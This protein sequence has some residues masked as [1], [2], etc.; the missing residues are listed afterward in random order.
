M[1]E[2]AIPL[3]G[4]G[5]L[6]LISNK[7]KD[8]FT[9]MGAEKKLQNTT[10]PDINYP[11]PSYSNSKQNVDN[12]PVDPTSKNYVHEFLNPNSATNKYVPAQNS[13]NKID[14]LSGNKIDAS[15]FKHN[16]MVPF[17]GSKTK[18]QLADSNI[19][20]AIL[21]NAQ[22]A[23]NQ[24]VKKV[25]HAP[26]FKPEDNVQNSNGN[27]NNNDFYQSRVI[28]GSKI[29][30]VLPWEQERVAPGLGL[31]Y[32]TNG[33]GGFNSGML[34]RE[35]WMDPTIDELRVKT[36][37]KITYGLQGH[38]GPASSKI[39]NLGQTGTIEKNR[40]NTDYALGPDRWF[41]TA[42][43][44][45]IA[46][47]MQS[48]ELIR[49]NHRQTTTKEY[50]GVG[51][52][53]GDAKAS[54]FRGEFEQS[55][56]QSLGQ[57][58]INPASA[59]GHGFANESD[60]GIKGFNILKNNRQANLTEN[61]YGNVGNVGGATGSFKAMI[62][63]IMDI[64]RPSRKENIVGNNNQVGNVTS[65]IPNLPI[66]NPKDRVKTTIKETTVDKV[67]LNYLNILLAVT[68]V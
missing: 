2:L 29:S 35:G 11:V 33:S 19:S 64:L 37:P 59:V 4:L 65:F 8:N 67:G 56:R 60:F 12:L 68:S 55:S 17:F 22:G 21:D 1:A 53:D 5:A 63:P 3:V 38:E 9:N 15:D 26:L 54:Y 50:F 58:D 18:G 46:P 28:P 62:A 13:S 7:K 52:N 40:Q 43:P 44:G 42:A 24:F 25:E 20:E 27:L 30:N 47:T 61:N 34:N 16:N 66:T 6:Y 14:S 51:G 48:E 36:N 45:Q 31:G 57:T 39:Q 41:T 23:G 49:D 32:N 10:I